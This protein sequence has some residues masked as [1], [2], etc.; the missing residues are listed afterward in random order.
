[1]PSKH[2]LALTEIIMSVFAVREYGAIG[3]ACFFDSKWE[4]GGEGLTGPKG[5]RNVR[6]A[7]AYARSGAAGGD[8]SALGG[9]WVYF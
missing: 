2:F 1:M 9:G 3:A 6:L 7:D 5:C 8:E 4:G